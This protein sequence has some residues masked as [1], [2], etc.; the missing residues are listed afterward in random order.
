MH[1]KK[2]MQE[3]ANVFQLFEIKTR[4]DS[5]LW[6]TF[7]NKEKDTAIGEQK[8]NLLNGIDPFVETVYIY[9]RDEVYRNPLLKIYVVVVSSEEIKELS[10]KTMHI[11]KNKIKMY[12]TLLGKASEAGWFTSHVGISRTCAYDD[13]KV[14]H[15]KDLA[16]ML[17]AYA[18][19]QAG[20]L[21]PA[22]VFMFTTPTEDMLK[23]FLRYKAQ[24][25]MTLGS[26]NGLV[27]MQKQIDVMND[28][29][30]KLESTLI[31][32]DDEEEEEEEEEYRH[33]AQQLLLETP[34][35]RIAKLKQKIEFASHLVKEIGQLK[36]CVKSPKQ[37]IDIPL[38]IN[39]WDKGK[40]L[41]LNVYEFPWIGLPFIGE[42]NIRANSLHVAMKLEKLAGLFP[43]IG[44][45]SEK[46]LKKRHIFPSP[47]ISRSI[48]DDLTE[49][50]RGTG[51]IVGVF[52]RAEQD[53][54][55]KEEE[56]EEWQCCELS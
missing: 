1:M 36:V 42:E 17:H 49:D 41:E 26:T 15:T 23:R 14:K 55:P 19:Q 9:Y 53:R 51:N 18:A 4:E 35:G 50:D 16:M 37:R 30:R 8:T 5:E 7:G 31:A 2:A 22:A 39:K 12:M 27:E 25:D 54:G 11:W 34:K 43:T 3:T 38:L 29:K 44:M 20:R 46:D 48:Q 6:S 33:A 56:T 21:F 45:A 47:Q 24:L 28:Q 40:E 10:L 13:P 32:E 52:M